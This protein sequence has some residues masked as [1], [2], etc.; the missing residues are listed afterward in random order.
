MRRAFQEPNGWYVADERNDGLH[1][2]PA[3]GG[4]LSERQARRLAA[5]ENL[6]PHEHF[7]E[8]TTTT[9]GHGAYCAKC[10]DTPT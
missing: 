8:A 7:C 10:G 9:D 3:D 1:F 5:Q 2:Q 4:R 6:G